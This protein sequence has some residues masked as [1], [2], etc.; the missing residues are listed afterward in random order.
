MI[1]KSRLSV[2]RFGWPL[3]ET[4]SIE[5]WMI[6]HVT[7]EERKEDGLCQIKRHTHANMSG[8]SGGYPR[9]LLLD[10]QRFGDKSFGLLVASLSSIGQ[11]ESACRAMNKI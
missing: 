6:E 2:R 10:A 3:M 1:A 5:I 9:N 4:T 7:G 11:L 8:C